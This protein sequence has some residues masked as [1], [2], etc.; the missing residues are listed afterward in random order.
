MFSTS[1]RNTSATR[2]PESERIA[3]RYLPQIGNQSQSS[4]TLGL[5]F[6]CLWPLEM[7]DLME[8]LL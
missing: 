6:E 2:I 1:E 4:H 3:F 5:K 7:N 8:R